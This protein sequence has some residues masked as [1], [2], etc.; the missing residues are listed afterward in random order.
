MTVSPANLG[1]QALKFFVFAFPVTAASVRAA[2]VWDGPLTTFTEPLGGVG[3]DPANQDRLTTGVWI[4]R[5]PI[6]GLYNVF[7]EGGSFSDLSTKTLRDHYQEVNHANRFAS[8][9][10]QRVHP[11]RYRLAPGF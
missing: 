1:F 9:S 2:T 10:G 6:M 4:T 8:Y 11:A 3:S 7:S 5:N